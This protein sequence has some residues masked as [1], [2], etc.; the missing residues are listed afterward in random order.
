V[1][2]PAT[3]STN[4]APAAS[5]GPGAPAAPAPAPA[6][7]NAAP[8]AGT[9][10]IAAKAVAP[11]LPIKPKGPKRWTVEVAAG[12]NLEFSQKDSQNYNGSIR[13]NFNGDRVRDIVQYNASYGRMEKETSVNR[14]DG[15]WKIEYDLTKSKRLY[16]FNAASAGR[17]E[18]R[19]EDLTWQ[20]S[21]GMGYKFIQAPKFA[22]G[23]DLGVSYQEQFFEDDTFKD[24]FSMRVGQNAS[25]KV[26]DLVTLDEKFEWYPRMTSL[27]DYVVRVEASA[28][29]KLNKTG[30]VFLNT[31]II[32]VY[33]TRPAN[34][35]VPNDFQLRSSVGM[36]F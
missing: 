33:D 23:G 13:Y 12:A 34:H 18:V 16:A 26:S 3:N 19:R 6:G 15:S 14:M 24:Y 5:V 25:W 31:A 20:D 17:D 9:N 4:K 27:G 21:A 10:A 22:L 29:V 7:T 35:V 11:V 2:A 1:P 36:K 32:D 28:T 8:P 30:S